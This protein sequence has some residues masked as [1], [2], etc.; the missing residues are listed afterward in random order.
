[1]KWIT[2]ALVLT[3]LGLQYQLW[4]YKGGLHTQYRS[5]SQMVQVMSVQ[6]QQ[7]RQQNALLRAQVDDFKNGYD[8]IAEIA[9]HDM[10]YIQDGE[11]FYHF[12]P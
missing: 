5:Q 3:F 8:A 7:L 6:N 2:L 12:D 11:T 10:G 9:R 1:M 4:L